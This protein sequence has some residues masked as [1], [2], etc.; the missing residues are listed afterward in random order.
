MYDEKFDDDFGDLV[1]NTHGKWGDN[2]AKKATFKIWN[3]SL[4]GKH[5]Q[6]P[7]LPSTEIFNI[8]TQLDEIMAFHANCADGN[9]TFKQGIPMGEQKLLYKYEKEGRPNFTNTYLPAAVFVPSYARIKLVEKLLDDDEGGASVLMCDTDSYIAIRKPGVKRETGYCL[10]DWEI[11]KVD[12]QHGGIKTFVGLGPKTYALKCMDG[13][14]P[15]PKTKGVRLS[16]AT[17]NLVN[18]K[19]FEDLAK[20]FINKRCQ[21]QVMVPQTNFVA[22]M[23]KGEIFTIKSLKKMGINADE[24]K[25]D[26]DEFGF[27]WP[28]GYNK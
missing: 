10:G 9:Y 18:F 25:G 20:N 15:G 11:E 24:A 19:V 7:I 17:E 14:T 21:K 4:W 6:T 2:P 16:Y 1:R 12:Y 26:I 3:N 8:D 23:R 27:I 5:A 28:F 22:N 13:Y